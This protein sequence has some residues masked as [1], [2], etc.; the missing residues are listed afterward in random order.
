[1]R[2]QVIIACLALALIGCEPR[3]RESTREYN[4]PKELE[5]CTVHVIDNGKLTQLYV[6]LC[7]NKTTTATALSAKHPVYVSLIE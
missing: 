1:M 7:P 3:S 2:K 5:H 4:L 6:V